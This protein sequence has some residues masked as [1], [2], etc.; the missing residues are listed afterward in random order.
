MH[1]ERLTSSSGVRCRRRWFCR[2]WELRFP[3]GHSPSAGLQEEGSPRDRHGVDALVVCKTTQNG[4]KKHVGLTIHKTFFVLFR[5]APKKA[6]GFLDVQRDDAAQQT[7]PTR[8][9]Q[10][11]IQ[12]PESAGVLLNLPTLRRFK[13]LKKTGTTAQTRA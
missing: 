9:P 13:N 10:K 12:K 3:G 8:A 6:S 1:R 5:P 4:D 7:H 11:C 2:R